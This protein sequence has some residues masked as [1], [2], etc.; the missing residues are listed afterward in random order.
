MAGETPWRIVPAGLEL[1]VR[2]TPRG[3]RDA[4]DGIETRADGLPVLK[5]R[6]RVAPE[7]G[8]ANAAIRDVLRAAL[9]CPARAV[10]L[11]GGATARIKTFRVEG[12]GEALA[13]R[14]AAVLPAG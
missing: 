5:V 8:A 14:L 1:R 3:G 7:D 11:T 2:A 10:Q 13:R 4:I 12:D 9:G 6:V